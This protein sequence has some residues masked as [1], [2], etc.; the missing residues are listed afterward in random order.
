V[1]TRVS[2]AMLAAGVSPVTRGRAALGRDA[3]A[4]LARER[5]RGV[6][7]DPLEGYRVV[8]ERAE[9]EWVERERERVAEARRA[10]AS[11]WKS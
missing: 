9:Q 3:E 11:A 7:V 10:R 8:E 1:V 4:Q 5:A 6:W 2:A